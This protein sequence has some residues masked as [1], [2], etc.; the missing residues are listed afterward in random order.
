MSKN[1]WY[2]DGYGWF[3]RLFCSD[4]IEDDVNKFIDGLERASDKKIHKLENEWSNDIIKLQ[5]N[6]ELH[7]HGRSV[8]NIEKNNALKKY[9]QLKEQIHALESRLQNEAEINSGIDKL[10]KQLE[11]SQQKHKN[12]DE[13]LMEAQSVINKYRNFL[14]ELRDIGYSIDEFVGDMAIEYDDGIKAL[15]KAKKMHLENVVPYMKPANLNDMAQY[16][17]I[18]LSHKDPS[19]LSEAAID[20]VDLADLEEEKPYISS[21][22]TYEEPFYVSS[23]ATNYED[24]MSAS[25]ESSEDEYDDQLDD[26]IFDYKF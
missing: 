17:P 14:V 16:P 13:K 20:G 11:E 1:N 26:F 15:R 10:K 19:S 7:K 6:I 8:V 22:A 5:D 2:M 21:A 23:E 3:A 25:S 18:G 9:D 12:V 24:T 4:V